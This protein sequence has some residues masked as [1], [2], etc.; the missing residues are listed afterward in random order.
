MSRKVMLTFWMC[1]SILDLPKVH[2]T[3]GTSL[4]WLFFDRVETQVKLLPLLSRWSDHLH[5]HA[6]LEA[7][8]PPLCCTL[9]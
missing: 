3:S 2:S 6:A 1:T 8:D 7:I 4:S 5:M 9:P